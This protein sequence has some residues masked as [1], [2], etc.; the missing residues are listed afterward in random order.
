M[1][2]P[3][4]IA[5]VTATLRNLLTQG[6]APDPDLSD[7]TVTLHPPDQARPGAA[8]SNQLNLFLYLA[9]PDAAWRNL[10]MPT[11]VGGGAVQFPPLALNLFYLITA[12][13]R[14]NDAQRPFSHMLLG[15]AMSILHDHPV[16]GADEIAA[17]LP[18][19]DLATQVE[20]VRLTLQPLSLE[21]LSKLWTAF[22]CEYRLCAA[23][24]A[25]VVLIESVRPSRAPL[26]V[27]RRGAEDRGA[28]AQGNLVPPF[29]QLVA[30]GPAGAV[31][32]GKVVTVSGHHLDGTRVQVRL[33]SP[34]LATPRLLDPAPGASS[35]QLT[36][37]LPEDEILPAG[38][39]RLAVV[40][41]S[42]GTARVTNELPLVIAPTITAGLPAQVASVRGTATLRLT[43]QSR[44]L[45]DQSSVLLLGDRAIAA[46]PLAAPQRELVFTIPDAVPGEHL[47]RVRIDGVDSALV[48]DP[49]AR[50]LS[51]DRAKLASIT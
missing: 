19:S 32:L 44:V 20:R 31:E 2:N 15:R 3:L 49:E 28:D 10:T 41:T 29:P 21:E 46:A 42:A 27:L 9:R 16:L 14:D 38:F 35:D 50:P 7:V 47:C 39:Y 34:R 17:A 1:S 11:R 37:T 48:A 6:L 5:A 13:G 22:Q 45:P 23:Y 8:S 24:E 36:V 40:I 30:L 25:A 18:D 51:F 12:Y 4:A 26:P 43:L 33:T